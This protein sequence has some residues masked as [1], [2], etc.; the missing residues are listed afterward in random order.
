MRF[1]DVEM[2]E[3]EMEETKTEVDFRVQMSS[4]ETQPGD[5]TD[6]P[7]NP[8]AAH[9][10]KN[11]S[12]FFADGARSV[13]FVIVWKKLMPHE[14]DERSDAL[15]QREVDDVSRKESERVERREVFEKNLIDEGLEL[16]HEIVDEEINFVKI[17]APLEVLR[18]YAEI[19]KLRLPMKEVSYSLRIKLTLITMSWTVFG[20]VIRKLAHRL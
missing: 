10:T 2:S 8:Y 3:D 13:D 7:Q 12:L 15:N 5:V 6:F 20:E 18:R 17:H 4:P 14:D 11:D 1:D 9:R 19:L 16:E